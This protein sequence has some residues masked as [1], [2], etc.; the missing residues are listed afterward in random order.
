MLENV[1]WMEKVDH[2]NKS[3]SFCIIWKTNEEVIMSDI[4]IEKHTF[5]YSKYQM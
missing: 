4:E 5:Y 3:F 1:V 2:Y